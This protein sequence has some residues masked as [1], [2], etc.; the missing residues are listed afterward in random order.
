MTKE[1]KPMKCYACE[2]I[3][4]D[5]EYELL[6]D[7]IVCQ[8]CFK[9]RGSI[10]RSTKYMLSLLFFMIGVLIGCVTLM[11]VTVIRRLL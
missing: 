6:F 4:T 1:K 10:S 9:K 11:V 8:I 7:K 5:D 2:R 3:I